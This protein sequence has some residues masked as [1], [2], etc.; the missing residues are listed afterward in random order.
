MTQFEAFLNKHSLT[1][2]GLAKLSGLGKAQVSEYRR[3]IHRPSKRTAVRIALTLRLPIADVLAQIPT[4]ETSENRPKPP[5]YCVT[6][7]R[8]LWSVASDGKRYDRAEV[9][10]K[11]AQ[12][13]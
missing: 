4:R 5:V 1:T 11:S 3:D 7:H 12:V 8:R 2:C 9:A 10:G 6:C 13:A